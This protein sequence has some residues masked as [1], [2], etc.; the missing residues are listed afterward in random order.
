[1]ALREHPGTQQNKNGHVWISKTHV[2]CII[3]LMTVGEWTRSSSH[4]WGYQKH[5]LRFGSTPTNTITC[6]AASKTRNLFSR[7]SSSSN[8]A[9]TFPHLMIKAL[10]SHWVIIL[11]I[12][13]LKMMSGQVVQQK[14]S[15]CGPRCG[16]PSSHPKLP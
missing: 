5:H 12:H 6:G 15:Y 1:M 8:M 7:L 2:M 11:T 13:G 14:T 9:A 3:Y 4:Q 16:S 10:G